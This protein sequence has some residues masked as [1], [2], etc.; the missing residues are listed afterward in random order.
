MMAY[1]QRLTLCKFTVILHNSEFKLNFFLFVVCV[2][3]TRQNF[4][5]ETMRH[6]GG[7]SIFSMMKFVVIVQNMIGYFLPSSQT[8]L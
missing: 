8:V 1:R 4:P 7:K 6:M 5:D 2:C 3:K